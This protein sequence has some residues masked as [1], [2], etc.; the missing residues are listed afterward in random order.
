[1]QAP[2]FEALDAFE[3]E[4]RILCALEHPCLPRFIE[5]FPHG[6]GINTRLYLA[7][8][9]IDGQSLQSL[10]EFYQALWTRGPAGVNVTLKVLH[11]P[12]VRD[13]TV[14]SID[15]AEFIRKRP[16]I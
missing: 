6:E 8:E 14:R 11:G 12:N 1:M 13:V 16:T 2:S 7:H 3:R 15:R 5:S 9:F 10:E 4:A